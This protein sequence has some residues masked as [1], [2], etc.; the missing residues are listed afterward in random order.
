MRWLDQSSHS[1]LR[2]L[3]I[4]GAEL[5][6]IL[7][8]R[9]QP[10]SSLHQET[11]ETYYLHS[12]TNGNIGIFLIFTGAVAVL[13][14]YWLYYYYTLRDIT[15]WRPAF[16]VTLLFVLAGLYLVF[17][18][19]E[20]ITVSRNC[21]RIDTGLFNR[22]LIIRWSEEPGLKLTVTADENNGACFW[23]LK[24]IDGRREYAIKRL[25]FRRCELRILGRH[26]AEF[27]SCP[28]TERDEQGS[29]TVITAAE[30]NIPWRQR[31]RENPP[32]AAQAVIKLDRSLLKISE[33][34]NSFHASWGL[35]S[36]GIFTELTIFAAILFA[37]TCLSWNQ[38]DC[39]FWSECVKRGD[40]LSY[41]TEGIILLLILFS[42]TGSRMHLSADGSCI[43]FR[44]TLWGVA[45]KTKTAAIDSLEDIR[46]NIAF[47]ESLIHAFSDE[48]SIYVR[49]SS[50]QDARRLHHQL[51]HFLIENFTADKISGTDKAE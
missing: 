20:S 27:L 48:Q 15:D 7:H 21:I 1:E 17:L 49:I 18:S 8:M 12:G 25:P 23:E 16:F 46:L 29:E 41:Y 30:H 28:F 39:S 37:S 32:S 10:S 43:T 31:I 14:V 47:R 3:S 44:H 11:E 36:K 19:R 45:L 38:G 42:V 5:K 4:V 9:H 22:P 26:L 40:F 6:R 35:N 24:L 51:Q 34:D 2:E 33:G 50:E 13:P